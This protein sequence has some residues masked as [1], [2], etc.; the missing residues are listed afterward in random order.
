MYKINKGGG[1]G[2]KNRKLGRTRSEIFRV[3]G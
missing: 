2:S 3:D 1:W